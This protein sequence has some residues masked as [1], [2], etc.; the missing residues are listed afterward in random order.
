MFEIDF[1]KLINQENTH[2]FTMVLADTIF[3]IRIRVARYSGNHH[4]HDKNPGC[5][6]MIR[7]RVASY[8]GNHHSHDKN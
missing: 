5:Q 4:S 3:M 1:A 6:V 7:I 2:A 8:S